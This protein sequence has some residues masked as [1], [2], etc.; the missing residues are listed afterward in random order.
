MSHWNYRII[1]EDG[2]LTLRE[3]F[4]SKKGKPDSWT[5]D[6]ISPHGEDKADLLLNFH[7]M[8][9]AFNKPILIV[10][11]KKLKVK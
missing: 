1:E 11:G 2:L 3:V 6:A 10:K 5:I 7:Q 4:Y 9:I 8:W